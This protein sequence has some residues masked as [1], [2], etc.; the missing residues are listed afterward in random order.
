MFGWG[1]RKSQSPPEI[2]P[3]GRNQAEPFGKQAD[4][5]KEIS[6]VE[7]EVTAA[8]RTDPG[9]LRETNEDSV[10]YTRPADPAVL[11]RKGVLAVVADGM[12]GHS[13]GEVAS[14]IATDAIN[15]VYYEIDDDATGALNSAFSEANQQIYKASQAD[16]ALEREWAQP[17]VALAVQDGFG[18][19]RLRRRQPDLPDT[20]RRALLDDRRSFGRHGDGPHGADNCCRGTPP[21]RQECHHTRPG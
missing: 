12:G 16:K 4:P 20:R 11:A 5:Q 19:L 1:R 6:S 3:A 7:Y 17:C 21:R 10:R 9:C 15:S 13:G 18:S 2:A 14:R 8:L